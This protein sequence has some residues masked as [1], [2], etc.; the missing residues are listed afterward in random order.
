LTLKIKYYQLKNECLYYLQFN[1]IQHAYNL[2]SQGLIMDSYSKLN[3]VEYEQIMLLNQLFYCFEQ[4]GI[5]KGRISIKKHMTFSYIRKL[6]KDSSGFQVA[7][8]I[9]E[10]QIVILKDTHSLFE[11]CI[12]KIHNTYYKQIKK[13]KDSRTETFL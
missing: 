8:T 5:V 6:N 10:T 3:D 7:V 4:I 2:F 11:H 1:E 12:D 9:I 13:L